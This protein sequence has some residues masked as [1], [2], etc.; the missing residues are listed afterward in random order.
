[1]GEAPWMSYIGDYQEPEG[2]S[3]VCGYEVAQGRIAGETIGNWL[4]LS[5][6]N[7]EMFRFGWELDALK[8]WL[9]PSITRG[10]GLSQMQSRIDQFVY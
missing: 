8:L 5:E 1:M 6:L 4:P 10:K 2:I 7:R 9:D 3:R